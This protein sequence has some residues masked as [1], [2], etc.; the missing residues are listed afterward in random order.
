MEFAIGNNRFSP[1]TN[2]PHSRTVQLRLVKDG[3]FNDNSPED[4]GFPDFP[5]F[6]DWMRPTRAHCGSSVIYRP[7]KQP[8]IGVLSFQLFF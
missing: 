6:P 4:R 8:T 5:D 2:P 1:L 3:L 7:L